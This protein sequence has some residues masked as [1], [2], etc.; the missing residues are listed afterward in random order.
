MSQAGRMRQQGLTARMAMKAQRWVG[1]AAQRSPQNSCS[2]HIPVVD[3][4]L[5]PDAVQALLGKGTG[6]SQS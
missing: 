6:G 1:E 2:G 5:G 4:S 3:R